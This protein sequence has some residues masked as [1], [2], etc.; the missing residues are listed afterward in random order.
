MKLNHYKIMD[1]KF[2]FTFLD[3]TLVTLA[4]STTCM[5]RNIISTYIFN[6]HMSQRGDTSIQIMSTKNELLEYSSI[7]ET[8]RAIP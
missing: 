6:N 3:N 2:F 5:N 8:L 4:L 1:R 7:S